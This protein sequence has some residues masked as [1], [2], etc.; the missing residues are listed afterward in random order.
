VSVFE[1]IR[2]RSKGFLKLSHHDMFHVDRV[3][4]L[5]V[6][7]AKLEK[8]D[9]D[10]VKAAVMLHDIARAMEDEDE[11]E[12]HSI[13]GAEM[14]KKILEEVGFPKKKIDR[15][16]HC[17]EAHR[18]KKG[19][20]TE[21]LEAKI[22]QDADR[23]DIIGAIGVARVFM[24]GGWGNTPMYDPSIPPKIR[25]DGKSETCVNHIFEKILKVKD[26]LN[27]TT[28]R[29]IAKSRHNFVEK[30]LD[31]FFKEWKGET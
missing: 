12:D 24:R 23:L 9:L 26:T 29:E 4:R 25:Y 17:I 31:R 11:I 14:A 6:Q 5:A 7:I 30:F 22:L 2:D 1:K 27:T 28:A 16:V 18:Y 10:V 3:H 15:V 21:S 19:T 8:A 20:K 13:K